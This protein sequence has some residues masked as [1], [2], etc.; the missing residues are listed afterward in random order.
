MKNF[1]LLFAMSLMLSSVAYASFPASETANITVIE[2]SEIPTTNS[3]E[4]VESEINEVSNPAP[5]IM[6]WHW[7]LRLLL[8]MA[9]GLVI[10]ALLF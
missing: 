9:I 4:V 3:I 10:V 8:G 2:K 5:G 6:D 1:L 7:T